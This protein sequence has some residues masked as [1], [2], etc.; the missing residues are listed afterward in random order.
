MK[1]NIISSF[2]LTFF[3]L[4]FEVNALGLNQAKKKVFKLKESIKK[5]ELSL[6]S[7]NLQFSKVIDIKNQLFE[8]ITKIEQGIDVTDENLKTEL[9]KFKKTLLRHEALEYSV[10]ESDLKLVAIKRLK[11]KK[12]KI[13]E[14]KNNLIN[15]RKT[16]LGLQ[17][18]LSDYEFL[19]VDLIRKIEKISEKVTTAKKKFNRESK[20]YNTLKK[21]R[22]SK[23]KKRKKTKKKVST[24]KKTSI[25]K[26]KEKIVLSFPVSNPFKTEKDESG[27]LNF[28]LGQKQEIM[29]PG[30]G[31]IIYSGRLSKYG[32]VIVVRHE[33]GYRSVL[34]GK[35]LSSVSKGQKVTRGQTIASSLEAAEGENKLYFEFRKKKKKLIAENFLLKRI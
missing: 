28:Y 6:K 25:D 14:N 24:I 26:V 2:I 5:F 18:K 8:D 17:D 7:T 10:E 20:K 3:F 15:L 29:S 31:T 22:I 9:K 32:N 19:E 11:N 1:K 35:F 23:S 30:N 13:I 27:G 16:L 33:N 34:L 12:N 21:K 4:C